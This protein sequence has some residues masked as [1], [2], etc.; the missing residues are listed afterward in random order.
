MVRPSFPASS[1][2]G[3]NVVPLRKTDAPLFDMTTPMDAST[4]LRYASEQ[5]RLEIV[6]QDEQGNS[7]YKEPILMLGME[8][9][10]GDIDHTVYRW[11]EGKEGHYWRGQKYAELRAHAQ[12]WLREFAPDKVGGTMPVSCI[13]TMTDILVSRHRYLKPD[14]SRSIVPLRNAYLTIESDGRILA[15]RPDKSHF[16]DYA[17]QADLDWSRVDPKT[18][19]YT[20]AGPKAGGYWHGYV[21]SAFIDSDVHDY[22]QEAL[23]SIL[24]SKCY[25]KGIILYGDGE[26][27]KSVMLHIL[28]ALAPRHTQSISIPRLVKNEFGTS[29][30]INKRVAIIGE[31]PSRLSKEMQEVLK[32]LISW[33]PMP[34]EFKGKDV[35]TF[36]PRVVV[37][38]ASNHFA[39][40][41][42]HEHGFW[43]KIEVIP[44]IKRV[45]ADQKIQDLHRHITT[46]PVE[47]AQVVDW[48]LVGASR[49]VKNGWRKDEDKPVA[50]KALA[51]EQRRD[52][53]SVIA[54]LHDTVLSY[55]AT[56]LTDKKKIYQAYRLY[57]DDGGKHALSEAKFWQRM[58]AN[59]RDFDFK[60]EQAEQRTVRG[61]RVRVVSLKCEGIAPVA[62][63]PKM[64]VEVVNDQGAT[65]LPGDWEQSQQEIEDAFKDVSA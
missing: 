31:M 16:I 49:L 53:D 60:P 52:T 3:N 25:E 64:N 44:F 55:E 6:D 65:S 56:V 61:Q 29:S 5:C 22:S 35:F 41:S 14:L 1:G 30:L 4:E 39:E 63:L 57:T 46:N 28:R 9:E 23:S 2:D 15:H 11:H 8:S 54:W 36:T 26:N 17:I 18:S 27:G 45:Q 51:D 50:V 32:S 40:V 33:D 47:M 62:F 12:S 34:G 42:N 21:A 58:K 13:R 43:R 20:P 10:G 48:L 38:G 37:V 24:V 59:F 7:I 19:I